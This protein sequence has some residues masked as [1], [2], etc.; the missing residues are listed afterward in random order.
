MKNPATHLSL[1]GVLEVPIF[2]S[3]Y[4][5]EGAVIRVRKYN[6]KAHCG[7]VH[8][9]EFSVLEYMPQEQDGAGRKTIHIEDYLTGR[10]TIERLEKGPNT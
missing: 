7:I 5:S 1:P 3:D 2:D 9:A 8:H 10:V 6:E 4:F